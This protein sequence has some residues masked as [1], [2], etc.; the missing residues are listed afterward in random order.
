MSQARTDHTHPGGQAHLVELFDSD[1][2]LAEGVAEFLGDGLVRNDQMLV[3]GTEERWYAILMRLAALGRPADDALR[4]GR[5]VVRAAKVTLDKF[6]DG[7][8]ISPTLFHAT[9]GTLVEGMAACGRPLRIYGEM[10]DVLASQGDYAN[11]LEL[12]RLWNQLATR[13]RFT[14]LCGYAA[15]HFGNPRN[16]EDLCRICAAHDGVRSK[17]EDVLGA[18]LVSQY[19]AA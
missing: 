2:S 16:A 6:M 17:P 3:V 13:H 10:V 7:G 4:S 8:R 9:V 5:L 14:L 1:E 18:F 11:A 19:H 12:E 15:G